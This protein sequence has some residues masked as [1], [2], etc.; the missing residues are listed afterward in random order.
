[1]LTASGLTKGQTFESVHCLSPHL[2]VFSDSK[3]N[4]SP[5]PGFSPSHTVFSSISY[6][7]HM[8]KIISQ[9]GQSLMTIVYLS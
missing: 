6:P 2:L 9:R 8:T 1:M 5:K 7:D 4:E 3:N